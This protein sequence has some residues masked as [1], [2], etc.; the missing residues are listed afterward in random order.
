MKK[1]TKA[2]EAEMKQ[3]HQSNKAKR[4]RIYKRLFYF[5]MAVGNLAVVAFL[6]IM[7]ADPET[8]HY[9][10]ASFSGISALYFTY[11]LIGE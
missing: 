8:G 5:L 7:N 6:V 3:E 2:Q 10:L 1:I 11:N 4:A 9:I